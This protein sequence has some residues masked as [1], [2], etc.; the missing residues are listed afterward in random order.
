MDTEEE[1]IQPSPRFFP[2]SIN[3][4]MAIRI[5]A[6]VVSG[7]ASK[8]LLNRREREDAHGWEEIKI[9]ELGCRL[10]LPGANT[11]RSIQI[12]E[13]SPA[14]SEMECLKWLEH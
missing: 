3:W 10:A 6:S 1:A 7:K 5:H 13:D 2:V 14:I 9:A 12:Y 4:I 8:S 11:D